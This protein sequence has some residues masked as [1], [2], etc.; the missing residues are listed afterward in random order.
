ML[1]DLEIYNQR[2]VKV[3]SETI[4][5]MVKLSKPDNFRQTQLIC[6]DTNITTMAK[7]IL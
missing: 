7:N 6:M 1:R 5:P 4:N 2:F 3:Q